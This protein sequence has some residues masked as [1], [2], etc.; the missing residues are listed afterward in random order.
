MTSNPDTQVAFVT[1]AA[2]GIGRETALELA[3]RGAD[4]AICDV[5][6]EALVRT[7][8]E[9]RALGA[10]VVAGC[11][12]VSD[13]ESMDSFAELVHACFDGVDLLVNNA[14]I[15]LVGGLLET[16]L[17]DWQRLIDINVMGVVHGI[18]SFVPHMIER[19]R[20]GHVVNIA[21]QAG[22]QASPA[23][24][25]YSATKFAVFGLTEALR[26][27]LRPHGI[28]VTAVCPGVINTGIT[29]STVI[30][31]AGAAER[32]EKLARLYERRGYGPEKVAV[33]ILRAVERDRAVAP[34]APEAHVAYALSRI[35]PTASR[36]VAGR[37]A[38][39]AQ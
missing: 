25:A 18:R 9:A 10:V 11:F 8:E 24:N 3:R 33:H 37:M 35:S 38:A 16:T 34:V 14:G 19:G 28:G 20:G 4:L 5:D 7:A 17:E 6:E 26:G 29:R 36:W 27:E 12:D 1:G 15:G 32:Q 22:Y 30:R 13:Q 23:L 39:A 21:S 2:G 31:G